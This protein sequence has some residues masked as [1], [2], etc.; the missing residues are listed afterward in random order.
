MK[1]LG[2]KGMDSDSEEAIK[3][4]TGFT[5]N[6]L[7][8]MGI[9]S[10][11]STASKNHGGFVGPTRDL[12]ADELEFA[13]DLV[14]EY[15]LAMQ[16]LT[17][18]E[19]SFSKREDAEEIYRQKADYVTSRM[20]SDA[21][22][23]SRGDV[24]K[25]LRWVDNFSNFTEEAIED[26]HTIL[27]HYIMDTTALY[28][29]YGL[30]PN[31]NGGASGAAGAGAGSGTGTGAGAAANSDAETEEEDDELLFGTSSSAGTQPVKGAAA[32]EKEINDI[33]DTWF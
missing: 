22:V 29:R 32:T 9:I 21:I 18:P 25:F 5:I 19:F 26:F 4:W 1:F 11:G 14:K 28:K 33:L 16:I 10:P 24:K 13:Q 7:L 2:N 15:T 30:V 12:T 20:L 8:N 3:Y 6:S 31:A 17:H 23:H 27:D